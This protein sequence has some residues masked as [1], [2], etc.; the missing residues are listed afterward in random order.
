MTDVSQN[1]GYFSGSY[2]ASGTGL[3]LLG[4][5]MTISELKAGEIDHALA[6]AIPDTSADAVTPPAQRGDG[7]T[8]GASAI[9]E[10]THLRIDPSLDLS[11]LNL[12]PTGLAIARAAQRYGIVVRDTSSVVTFYA[13]DP[14]PT[15]SDPYGRI[16]GG[17]WPMD[18]L[19]GFPWDHLQVVAPPGA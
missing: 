13:E 9:P 2:G 15:G 10:G 14:H 8:T 7:Q 11:T 5:L 19:A 18:V 12:T 1:P 17:Q 4:G 16:F 6:I 3:P